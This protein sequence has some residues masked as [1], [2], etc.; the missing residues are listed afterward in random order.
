MHDCICPVDFDWSPERA[1]LDS[2]FADIFA[3]IPKGVGLT[4]VSDSCH[5]GNLARTFLCNNLAAYRK[6]R[7]FPVPAD[8]AWRN[9]TAVESGVQPL[10]FAR[11][12]KHLHGV[13]LAGCKSEQTSADAFIDGRFCG[14][15]TTALL[16]RLAEP[17]GYQK[18]AAAIVAEANAWLENKGY[19]QDPQIKGDPEHVAKPWL[20]V[21]SAVK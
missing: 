14:A 7:T 18:P 2:D 6:P 1:L 11:S 10:G 3:G 13:L 12:V 15:F 5:S 19:E 17:D 4:W 16:A 9:A 21:D 8:I 20:W